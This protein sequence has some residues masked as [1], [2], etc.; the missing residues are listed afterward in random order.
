MADFARLPN[1]RK[2]LLFVVAGGLLGLLYFQFLYKPLAE[3]K[4]TAQQENAAKVRLNNKLANDIP[5][6]ENL[7]KRVKELD[8]RIAR[9]QQA[10]PTEAEVPAFFEMLERKIKQSGV[11][12]TRWTKQ[13]EA[14]VATF[15]KVPVDIELTGSF[16]QIKRFFASL[17]QNDVSPAS[18]QNPEQPE[19]HERIVSIENL[20][21]VNPVVRNRE[22]MLTAKF[23]AVTYRQDEPK[24]PAAAPPPAASG[25][26]GP[27]KPPMPSAAT[28]AGAKVRTEDAM[29][30]SVDRNA[31][32][33]G[34]KP[35]DG[36]AGA[37]GGN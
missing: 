5:E 36:S 3:D 13:P 14:P 19:E 34:D 29:Q 25:T 8:E 27:A 33:I 1:D 32:G 18:L 21:L 23:T 17:V 9:N 11:E 20:S 37:K 12:I 28:P 30:K 15:M 4:D 31:K 35:A 10:L 24:T 7:K 2:V 6:Y 26:P 22:I 16:M